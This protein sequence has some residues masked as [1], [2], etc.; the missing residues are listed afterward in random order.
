MTAPVR[1]RLPARAHPGLDLALLASLGLAA[2]DVLDLCSAHNPDAPPPALIAAAQSALF[3]RYPDPSALAARTRIA[4][5]W[6]TSPEHVLLGNGASELAWSCAR[7]LLAA[8]SS[9]LSIEPSPAEFARAARQCGARVSRW[10]SVERT[11]H[12]VD[13]DQVADLMRPDPPN[14]V[15]LYAP[16]N[17]SGS[18]VS[19]AALTQLAAAF[20][21]T[22][23]VVDQSWLSLSDDHAELALLP[24]TNVICLRSLSAELRVPGVRVGYLLASADVVARGDALRPPFGINAAA[25]AVALE[26][27]SQLPSIAT[28]RS[29]LQADRARLASVLDQLALVYAPSV[30]PFLLVRVARASEV[31]RELLQQHRIAVCDATPF[32]L[33]DH[34]RIAALSAEQQPQLMAA[35]RATLDRRQLIRGREP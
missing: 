28:S 34:L 26:Y 22:H 29:R 27:I 3:T 14:V 20:P 17:P 21:E 18:R 35:L 23:F 4:N 16:G 12:H 19:F 1:P 8:G 11:G 25:Q 9:V 31:S 10:R 2:D 24:A 13:L 7:A 5:H 33:P 30:A 15:S 6:Q 32:G